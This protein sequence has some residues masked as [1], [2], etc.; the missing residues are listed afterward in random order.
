MPDVSG[1]GAPLDLMISDPGAVTWLPGGGLVLNA[2]VVLN[3][4]VPATKIIDA[5]QASRGVTLEAWVQAANLTQFGPARILTLSQDGYPNGGNFMLSQSYAA[6]DARLRTT[7]TDRYGM[8]GLSAANVLDTE[9]RHLVYTRT[10]TGGTALYVDGALVASGSTAGTFSNWGTGYTLTLGNEPPGNRTWLGTMYLA[11]VYGRALDAAEVAQNFAAGPQLGSPP[12]YTLTVNIVGNGSVTLD[13]AGGTYVVGTPV[14]LTAIAAPD[15]FFSGWSGDLGDNDNPATIDVTGD[16]T[17]TATFREGSGLAFFEDYEEGFTLGVD[18]GEHSEWFD[19]TGSDGSDVTAG[20]GVAGSIGLAP[21]N[22]IFT[23]IAHPFGWNA[24]NFQRVSFQMDFQTDPSGNFDDDRLGWMTTDNDP[25]SANIFGVQLDHSDGGIVTYWRD[26]GGT[27]IQDPIVPLSALTANTWFRFRASIIKLTAAAAR[28]EVSLVELDSS[29]NPTG[30]PYIGVVEN[31]STWPGGA[32]AAGY[33]TASTMWAGYKNYEALAGAADNALLEVLT[34]PATQHT[35]IV[36]TS[37]NGHV[38]AYPDQALYDYGETVEL[39]ALPDPAWRFS[40]WSGDFVG[41]ANPALV[42][43][44]GDMLITA[45]FVEEGPV[46]GICEDFEVGYTLGTELREHPDWFYGTAN[47]GPQPQAGI[48]VDGTIGLTN[49]N[50]AFTWVA[51]EFDWND[52]DLAGVFFQMDFETD[53]SGVFDDD[54]LGWSISDT[55]DSSDNIFGVQMDPG[56]TGAGG[57]IE[58]YWDG[59]TAGDDGG[60]TSIV[61]LPALAGNTYYRLYAEFTKLTATSVKLD[62]TL[63]ELDAAGNEIGVVAAGTLSDTDLLPDT[64]GDEIPNPHYFMGPMWPVFKNYDGVDGAADNACFGI[65]TPAPAAIR[66]AAFGDYGWAGPNEQAVADLVDGFS[67]DFIVTTGDNSYGSADIDINIGQYYG[68]YIGDYQ[69]TYGPGSSENRFFPAIGN[70]DYTDG[71]GL[72]AYLGYFTLPGAGIPGSGSSG[73]ERYYDFV[74]GPVHFFVIDSDPSGIGSP[75]APGDGR[76][77][78]SPQGV[79]LQTQLAASTAPW[80]IV[81]MHHPPYSSGSV[82]GS[83]VA[84]QWPYEQWGATAVLAGH[85]HV[86]ERILR[87]DNA[88]GV[89]FPYFTT[90]AGGRSLYAFTTPVPGSQVRYSDDYGSLIIDADASSITFEFHSINPSHGTGGLIDTYTVGASP[91]QYSLTVNTVG[92][93]SVTLDPPGGLYNAGTVVQLTATADPGWVFSVWSGDLSGSTNPETITMDSGHTATATF[94]ESPVSPMV[95]EDFESG[96]T[97]GATVGTHPDWFDGGSGPLVTAGIGAAGSLGLAPAS[98]IFIWANQP[99]DWNAPDF[100]GVNLRLDFQTSDSGLFDDDRVGWMI[101]NDSTSS[102]N[103]F[104]VQL[105]PGGSGQN[106]EC[107]WDGDSFGDDGGR[108]SIV[109]LPAL[110]AN[111]WYRMQAAITRL[112]AT[113]A[114]IDVTLWELDA[115]GDLGPVV[116]T[117]SIPDTDLLPNTSGN[118]IPNP[119]YFTGPIWPAFKNYSAVGGAADNACYEVITG[120]VPQYT[121]TVNTVGNGSVSL[122]PAGGVYDAGTVVHLTAVADPGWEFSAWSGDLS[123]STNP[124]IVTM[125]GDLT[126]TANFTEPGSLAPGDVIISSMQAWNSPAGQNPGEF[127][128]LFNTTDRTIPLE[129]LELI[130]WVDTNSDGVVDIDWQLTADM[131]G[132]LIAPHSFFLVAESAVVALGGV[133]DVETALDLATGEGGVTERAI[134]LELVI[135]DVHMDYVVYGRWDGSTPAGELPPGDIA[136]DGVSWPRSEVIRNT[137]DAASYTEGLLRRESADDLYAG[138]AVAGYYTDEDALGGGYPA[139]VW[140]SPHDETYGSYEVRNSLSPAVLP[141][142]PPSFAFVVVTDLHTS[143]YQANVEANLLQVRDWIDNPSPE[144]PAPE[145]MVIT[146]DFPNI[147]QTQAAIDNSIGSGFLWYPVIGNHEISD[148]FN[149]F[150]Y[151]SDTMVPSLPYVDDYGP[152]G[153]ENTSYSWD[154]GNAHFV[155]VNIYWDGTTGG[156]ADHATDGDVPPALRDWVDTNVSADAS[157]HTFV[158]VHEP[159]YPDDRHVGDSLDKYPANRDAFVTMLDARGVAA[160][161]CGHTHYYDHYTEANYP[162]LGDVNQITNAALR[163]FTDQDGAGITYVLVSGNTTTFKIYRSTTGTPFALYEEWSV[164]TTPPLPTYS[165]TV[166]IVGNGQV[167]LDPP[168]NTYPAGSVVQLTA[169]ADPGW[170]FSGWSGDLTGSDNPE[171]ITMTGAR[172][173]TAT[174][175]EET[176][177][178]WIS[179]IDLRAIAGDNNATNVLAIVPTGPDTQPIDPTTSWSLVDYSSGG[180]LPVTLNVAMDIRYPTTNGADSAPGT[181]AGTTFGGIIDGMGGYEIDLADT[182]DYVTLNFTNLDPTKAYTL[183]VTY[184]RDDVTYSNRVTRFTLEGADTF[185]NA[186]TPGVFVHSEE[187]VS[188][189]TGNNTAGGYVARWTGITA[190]DGSIAVTAVQDISQPGWDGSKAYAMTS[191]MLAQGAAP[192]LAGVLEDFESGFTLGATVGTHPDWFDGG[193]G[194]LVTA[195]IGAAGSLGLAPAS[196]IFIWANQPFDWNAPDFVGV[197]LRLDFQ[198]SDSGLFDDDRVGWMITNDSTSSNNIFGVQLDPGGSGQNIECYWDGDSF[199]DDG[200]RTSIVDLPALTANAWYRM[201]AAI[202]RL[203]ATSARIDVTLWELDA[204]GDLGPVVV[205]GSIPDTDLLPN[206]S[207]NEIPNP[208]YFTGPIWPAFKN[209][210]A[211]GGA[212]DNACYEVITTTLA[213]SKAKAGSAEGGMEEAAREIPNAYYLAANQPNP[214]NPNTTIRFGLLEAGSVELI[215]F[216]ILGQ[217]IRT[218]VR[219]HYPAG[220]HLVI[221]DGRNDLG[222]PVASGVYFYRLVNPGFKQVRKMMLIK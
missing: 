217:K 173:V 191:I 99:F 132:R 68:D 82:H 216:D 43:I 219:D 25:S 163:N 97:L 81:I 184:N 2:P 49:G 90:G 156:G 151:I 48:G 53:P 36:Q 88:D 107:Y 101:T 146:G 4:G 13:P 92:N 203:T 120:A 26:A 65:I 108:T 177:D 209:Y 93:G 75:P 24:P 214:F 195:G 95:C 63:T 185:T 29:G 128:E 207:G 138:Y 189:S 176:D 83:E 170:V 149:N 157:D 39:T 84:M 145:F 187:S 27:R 52:P 15:W 105:D 222:R 148:D 46:A 58:C 162:L 76:A 121:L 50:R 115:G 80:K 102:N 204:G 198:T 159:A 188:F 1:Q 12:E 7:A 56:G 31:T 61:D 158:F 139:G 10:D 42:T 38:T 118:E 70:H 212:A 211:V 37:G 130:S 206:T 74:R 91:T 135:D 131:T 221:W 72:N 215:I 152:A 79:W 190:A 110:T 32:P 172:S 175:V 40:H 89:V 210:S 35:L 200:G 113:S 71:G 126:V 134:S 64:P 168:G 208:G 21:G 197:N 45:N 62:V 220:D 69:G 154:F 54:R 96:F 144:M 22:T 20:I 30:T 137:R 178:T 127:V 179:Y 171:S 147:S 100:V 86:Y 66:F 192:T 141:P 18:V 125:N 129:G 103:I 94:T 44:T 181:D 196:A 218:L 213:R 98:A 11:A 28:I 55:D 174:F 78:D 41:T 183:A 143:S 202:T 16:L 182:G 60:R 19:G 165:L 9:L 150:I 205:T 34:G 180:P 85:D 111:A 140:Y 169:T 3:S 124:E 87:D 193:S 14:E 73:S 119:G 8:P 167:A 201:Q 123:G 114:R 194:P 116:V 67:P 161:F 199:G 186:S 160:L 153:S 33:F 166:N 112:T 164:S 109:D 17:V 77:P 104:G 57:N 23:W 106:I 142:A 59:D 155:A 133:H 122:D 51:H 136:F 5:C 6:L 47:S 117:G